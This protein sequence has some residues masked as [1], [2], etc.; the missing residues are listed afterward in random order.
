[1]EGKAMKILGILCLI[2]VPFLSLAQG[3]TE[4]VATVG[5]R[6]ITLDEFNKKYSAVLAQI[7]TNPPTKQQFLED[8]VRFELGTQAAEKNGLEKDPIVRD[9][10]RQELYKAQLEKDLAGRLA[11]INI[12]DPEMKTWY[13]KNPELKTSHILIQVKPGATTA[14]TEEARKR[15]NEIFQEVKK[16]KRPFEELVKLYSDD[17]LSK[18]AGG[19]AGWQ[20]RLTLVPS[21]YDAALSTKVGEIKGP[22]ETRFGFHIIKV[23][24]RRSFEDADKRQIRGAIY[25][26]KRKQVLDQ[27]F[28]NLKNQYSVKVNS[29]LLK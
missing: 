3:Q 11:A 13:A 17:I 18:Q 5:S 15:A 10:M 29:N 19:D 4:V 28:Q 26:E 27:Y 7:K 25:E 23:T 6:K 2:V 8:L 20:S 14:Q 9:R 24:G 12:A 21:Y 22:V 1:M 16:S